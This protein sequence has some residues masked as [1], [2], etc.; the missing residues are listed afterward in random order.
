MAWRCADIRSTP[1]RA[2]RSVALNLSCSTRVSVRTLGEAR[3]P[4][5]DM[6]RV[7]FCVRN[8]RI[9]VAIYTH[10]HDQASCLFTTG[11]TLIVIVRLRTFLVAGNAEK[12]ANHPHSKLEF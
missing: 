11:S 4:S 2:E 3:F 10:G 5:I 6:S 8:P 7:L 1:I 9:S 12:G